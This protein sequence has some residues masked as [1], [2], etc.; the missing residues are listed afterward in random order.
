M[1]RNFSLNS[2]SLLL[3]S[4]PNR[5]H[6][7]S[8]LFFCWASKYLPVAEFLP[9]GRGSATLSLLTRDLWKEQTGGTGEYWGTG[10]AGNVPCSVNCWISW[11]IPDREIHLLDGFSRWEE[12]ELSSFT[13]SVFFLWFVQSHNGTWSYLYFGNENSPV[14]SSDMPQHQ[15]LVLWVLMVSP[16]QHHFLTHGWENPS[17]WEQRCP[18]EK[19]REKK[20]GS[21]FLL[22]LPD[23]PLQSSD[24]KD[25]H[26]AHKIILPG[27]DFPQNC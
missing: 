1:V 21:I 22:S 13:T 18:E 5:F 16:G 8:L 25:L 4:S 6:A 24:L 14:F 2:Q 12:L 10:K 7:P 26:K 9:E 27:Y 3:I 15:H 17:N 19:N 23:L 20:P 11:N